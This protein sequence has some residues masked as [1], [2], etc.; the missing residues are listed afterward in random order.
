MVKRLQHELSKRERQIMNVI[1]R[2]K[3]ATSE[4]V[5]KQIPSPPSYSAVR[6]TMKILEN[7]G[8]LAHRK[9]GRKYLFLPTVSHQRARQSA[10]RQLLETYFEGSVEAAVAALLQSDRSRL[11]EGEYRRLIELIRQEEKGRPK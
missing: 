3:G 10:V 7:K 4:Q 11:S 6:A 5:W 9:E 1:Y 2:E 8:F